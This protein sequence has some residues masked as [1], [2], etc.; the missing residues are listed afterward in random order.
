MG[1]TLS[2]IYGKI[3]AMNP[4]KDDLEAPHRTYGISGNRF[5]YCRR[6]LVNIFNAD[7]GYRVGHNI[8]MGF[9]KY[10]LD[11]IDKTMHGISLFDTDMAG[12]FRFNYD[13]AKAYAKEVCKYI[14]PS[15]LC[16]PEAQV[17]VFLVV[18]YL[19]VRSH[20]KAFRDYDFYKNE[21]TGRYE[22]RVGYHINL[23]LAYQCDAFVNILNEVITV[24]LEY[25]FKYGYYMR[26]IDTEHI[27]VKYRE[28]TC[29]PTPEIIHQCNK[30]DAVRV[31]IGIDLPEKLRDHLEPDRRTLPS[32]L[33]R[34]G[35]MIATQDNEPL[36]AK[37][38]AQYWHFMDTVPFSELY[39]TH[40]SERV[41]V[42]YTE[43][44]SYPKA[45]FIRPSYKFHKGYWSRR[46]VMN[47]FGKTLYGS[48]PEEPNYTDM[49]S[50]AL[51]HPDK[52]SGPYGDKGIK[53]AIE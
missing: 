30:V 4:P 13:T 19:G 49:Y 23:N 14:D 36:V 21:K 29:E 53:E 18:W 37:G 10:I 22:I 46:G 35:I 42:P 50:R 25:Y 43:D 15:V 40:L 34:E 48:H 16:V 2:E 38:P 5:D 28:G 47:L 12:I 11:E 27:P 31:K 39:L 52:V 1:Q 20:L 26:E 17:A 8:A 51:D 7:F 9:H 3:V 44:I 45:F 41:V 24:C 32:Y 33:R 6:N